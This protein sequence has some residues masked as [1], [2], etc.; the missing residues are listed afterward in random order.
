MRT[1]TAAQFLRAERANPA[2]KVGL[3]CGATGR[4]NA[5]MSTFTLLF[6]ALGLAI[7]A[8]AVAIA[9][10][11][12]LKAVTRRQV[13]RLS[14]HLGLFQALM[15]VIGWLA[16]SVVGPFIVAW[17]HWLAFGLL[18]F[19]GGRAIYEALSRDVWQPPTSDPTRGM[20]LV[21]LSIAT[22][23]DA[24]AVG[25]TLAFL[26]VS[27]WY[28][29]VVIGVVAAALTALGMK[30]GA[31]IGATFGRRIEVLGGLI[32]ILLGVKI[33]VEHLVRG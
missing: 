31:R 7:D 8:F 18:A 19:V 9:T 28:A 13:F 4:H 1:A 22:S 30:L 24:L 16:G 23:I 32:L 27:I 2:A 12:R 5:R 29:A 15:P 21:T 26:Q 20:M 10:S 11:I 17:D 25:V 33:L 14:F 6:I 3:C